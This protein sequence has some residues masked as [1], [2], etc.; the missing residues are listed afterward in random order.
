MGSDH[1]KSFACQEFLSELP[2]RIGF[3]V[4]FARCIFDLGVVFVRSCG[5]APPASMN[6]CDHCS[7]W[8]EPDQHR[9]K[10]TGRNR[11]SCQGPRCETSRGEQ[12]HAQLRPPTGLL[13]FIHARIRFFQ[14]IDKRTGRFRRGGPE[15]EVE[16]RPRVNGIVCREPCPHQIQAPRRGF[17]PSARKQNGKLVSANA[18]HELSRAESL[19][20]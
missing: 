17:G 9:C 11:S 16:G 7:Q 5:S 12:A 15:R 10:D 13:L 8:L 3:V 1:A 4:D 18:C 14:S 19:P 6:H 20:L 2:L